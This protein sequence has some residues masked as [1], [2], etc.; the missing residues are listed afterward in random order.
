[1]KHSV[2]YRSFAI[3]GIFLFAG[4]L[5]S[6]QFSG[7]VL[8]LD[9]YISQH[10]S[11]LRIES[12]DKWVIALTNLNGMRESLLFSALLLSFLLY[13]K[14][15]NDARFYLLA[16]AGSIVLF[17]T[18]KSMVKRVRPQMQLID[19]SGYSFPSGHST[20]SM[21]MAIALYFIFVRKIEA[22]AGRA[23]LLAIALLWPLMIGVSRIYLNVHWFSDVI[24]G[25]GLGLLWVMLLKLC[26]HRQ[27][28][29]LPATGS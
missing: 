8:Q 10:V 2:Y 20:M 17:S 21:A 19:I 3:F 25:L 13:K 26:C 29:P 7:S 6:V 16:L 12:W 28:K 23:V 24:G 1:M 11:S 4:M 18:V 14:W 9:Q 22:A 15:Y 27:E 5:L